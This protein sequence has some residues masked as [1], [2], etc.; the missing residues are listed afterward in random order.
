MFLY[1]GTEAGTLS[2]F[3]VRSKNN[4]FPCERTCP[5]KFYEMLQA[6]TTQ[7]STLLPAL[8][9]HDC[10]LAV[11]DTVTVNKGISIE[12]LATTKGYVIARA[13]CELVVFNATTAK[14]RSL[15]FVE[16]ID[17]QSE[18]CTNMIDQR[19]IISSSFVPPIRPADVT[20]LAIT[21]PHTAVVFDSKLS[22]VVESSSF[23]IT[24]LRLPVYIS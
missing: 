4:L 10:E 20:F 15:P 9:A 7:R 22:Y 3:N 21:A 11:V 19:A 2:V 13:A 16:R 8:H 14:H 17:L 23:N 18:G 24:S 1:A 6:S 5:N 12:A